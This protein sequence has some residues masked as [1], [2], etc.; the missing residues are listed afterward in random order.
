MAT[1]PQ[2]SDL[3]PKIVLGI[4][5]HPDDLDF[6]AGGTLAAFAAQSAA[7]HYLQLTDGCKGTS[8]PTR[9][10]KQVAA[11]RQQEQ[12]RACELIGG[13]GV[14]FL[15]HCDGELEVTTKLK[16]EIVQVIRE[17]KPD[18]VITTDPTLVYDADRG[19]INHSDHRAAGQA[20]LDAV[21]PLA[22]DPLTY[23]EQ[24]KD[25][26]SPHKVATVLLINPVNS[27]YYV[28]TTESFA[29]QLTAMQAHAS[30]VSDFEA[31]RAHFTDRAAQIGEQA[32]YRYAEGFVRIDVQIW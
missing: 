31:V 25:G 19:M 7:V 3:K 12:Q 26:L 22:R 24:L 2:F 21:Y 15:D 29:T 16:G 13:A 20:A 18:V 17:L 23:P 9:T 32:G 6:G 5:A 28:D 8:D 27:N 11:T 30:Q 1:T 14:H 10:P 4:A